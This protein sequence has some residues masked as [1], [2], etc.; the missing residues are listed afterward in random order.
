MRSTRTLRPL[1]P[2]AL[3]LLGGVCLP[4]LVPT[5]AHAQQQF[6]IVDFQECAKQSKL[7]KDLDGQFDSFKRSMLG[8]FTKLKEGN[9]IFL[10]KQEMGELA[11]IYEKGD[12]ATP[13][14]KMRAADLQKKADQSAGTITRLSQ[15][16]QLKDDEK[17]ELERLNTLQNE[18]IPLLNEIGA[19]YE[20]RITEKGTD[21]ENQ[22]EKAVKDAVKKVAQEKSLALVFNANVVIYAATDIT[23]D[24]VKLLQ[25]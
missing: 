19:E 6:G 23:E 25:K 14:E 13:A 10:T 8:I 18:G 15:Q 2:V 4:A 22:L 24:V 12:K 5:P 7:K 9:A 17:K 11:A 21:F 16:A 3:A 1:L 20:K